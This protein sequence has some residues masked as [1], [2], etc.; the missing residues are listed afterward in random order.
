[1]DE[2]VFAAAIRGDEAIALGLVEP[3]HGSRTHMPFLP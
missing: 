2:D 1:M 3:F